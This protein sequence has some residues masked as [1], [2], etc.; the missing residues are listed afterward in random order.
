MRLKSFTV[1][2]L[3]SKI[4]RRANVVVLRSASPTGS[5]SPSTSAGNASTS[6][7]N[8]YRHGA[9]RKPVA[10][11]APASSMMPPENSLLK[12]VFPESLLRAGAIFSDRHGVSVIIDSSRCLLSRLAISIVGCTHNIGPGA[13]SI[14]Y[15]SQLLPASVLPVCAANCITTRCTGLLLLRQSMQSLR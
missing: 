14:T 13:W 10:L 11:L 8:K 2:V 9:E 3:V 1:G 12:R 4:L 15:P 6:S 7:Q 5:P